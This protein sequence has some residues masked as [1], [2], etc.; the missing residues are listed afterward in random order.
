MCLLHEKELVGLDTVETGHNIK[1]LM[2][3]ENIS[4][5][6]LSRIMK[7]SFQAVCK[8]QRGEALPTLSNMYFLGQILGTDVDDILI[9]KKRIDE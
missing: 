8:W 3:R 9:G 4:T 5:T 6:E 7:V 2:E 1:K